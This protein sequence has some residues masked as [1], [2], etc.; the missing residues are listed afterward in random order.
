MLGVSLITQA[1]YLVVF[2]TRYLDLFWVP[3]TYSLYLFLIKIFYIVTSTYILVL[4][5]RVYARTRE[6]EKAWKLGGFATVGSLVAAPLFDLIFRKPKGTTFSEVRSSFDV[7]C[8]RHTTN[9]PLLG[10]LDIFNNP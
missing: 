9:V 5:T 6:R 8:E 1:L 7:P 2:S 4:M 3:P 10:N